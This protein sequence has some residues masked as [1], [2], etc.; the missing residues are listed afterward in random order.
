MEQ[1]D[2]VRAGQ[3][4]LGTVV[5]IFRTTALIQLDHSGLQVEVSLQ[6]ITNEGL[7]T[8]QDQ[9]RTEILKSVPSTRATLKEAT[10][11]SLKDRLALEALRF[12]LVPENQLEELT[13]NYRDLHDWIS[14]RLSG[15]HE[16]KPQISEV[17]G[18]FGSGKSHAMAT[19]RYIARQ[20]GYITARVE[21]DGQKVSLADPEFLLNTLWN[22]VS[23]KALHPFT[24]LLD[25]CRKAIQLGHS[26]PHIAPRG[27]D[28]IRDNYNTSRQ[29]RRPESLENYGYY[30]N[31]IMASSD[32]ITAA[33]VERFIK[34]DPYI[35]SYDV[36]VRRM[37]GRRVDDRPFDF[38]EALLGY[39]KLAELAG[40]KGLVITID[41]FEVEHTNHR[42]FSR[43]RNLLTV[44]GSYWKNGL[45]HPDV[46]I[47]VFFAT[48]PSE[49]STGDYF[50]D[51]L[52]GETE[53]G[54][55]ELPIWSKEDRAQFAA[56]VYRLYS[57]VYS[58]E[59]PY[60]RS[61][62]EIVERSI[63]DR[64]EHGPAVKRSFAKEY[65]SALDSKYGPPGI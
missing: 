53:E 37:I 1:G 11:V 16:G 12:G 5:R 63:A 29:L 54:F 48:V 14:S 19:I 3:F 57:Q 34:S 58:L 44:L 65:L 35:S 61:V 64:G 7:E 13:I 39:A 56:R 62:T 17:C 10:K 42:S 60:D 21:V 33:E 40:Y 47:S 4:C 25:L 26:A 2:K 24:A 20:T 41:E 59:H 52:L 15:A 23:G 9:T 49:G 6:E 55:Y 43:V 32:E 8:S 22:S 28:R 36:K 30:L 31:A 18:P 51:L 38:L 45:D 46:P 27:I 50:I